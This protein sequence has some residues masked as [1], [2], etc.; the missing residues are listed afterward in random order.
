MRWIIIISGHVYS[1]S[2]E[3]AYKGPKHIDPVFYVKEAPFG[4][5]WDACI[6]VL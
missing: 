4:S 2:Q 6:H 5:A 3:D 1:F